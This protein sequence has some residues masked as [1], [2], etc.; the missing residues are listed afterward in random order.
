MSQLTQYLWMTVL[1]AIFSVCGYLLPSELFLLQALHGYTHLSIYGN[2]DIIGTDVKICHFVQE[3][4]CWG[5][6]DC[7]I[8]ILWLSHF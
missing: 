8:L 2:V 7:G 5:I 3:Q 1:L 6:M 4:Y